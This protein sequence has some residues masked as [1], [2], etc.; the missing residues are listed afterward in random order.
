LLLAVTFV[1]SSPIDSDPTDPKKRDDIP[2]ISDPENF[3]MLKLLKIK[4]LVGSLVGSIL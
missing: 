2:S 4:F 1:S 3:M